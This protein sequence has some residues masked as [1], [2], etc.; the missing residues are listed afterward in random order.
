[1]NWRMLAIGNGE[2]AWRTGRK[3]TTSAVKMRC[4]ELDGDRLL[5]CE[6]PAFQE[7]LYRLHQGFCGHGTLT[8]TVYQQTIAADQFGA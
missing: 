8:I 1:M 3:L 6:C 2:A 5:L 4:I 7:R